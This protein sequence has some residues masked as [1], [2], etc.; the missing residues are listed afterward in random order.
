MLLTEQQIK[1]IILEEAKKYLEEIKRRMTP[2]DYD[3]FMQ[4]YSA[5]LSYKSKYPEPKTSQEQHDQ[6][7]VFFMVYGEA[8]GDVTME[9]PL[10]DWPLCP[11]VRP[12][13]DLL[14][15]QRYLTR[16]HNIPYSNVIDEDGDPTMKNPWSYVKALVAIHSKDIDKI[17]QHQNLQRGE[18]ESSMA[19][20]KNIEKQR[21]LRKL[22][23]TLENIIKEEVIKTLEKT[24]ERK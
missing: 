5:S 3:K 11:D 14:A 24:L 12:C 7:E 22:G 15:V 13:E 8:R 17:K 6:E 23:V 21:A 18:K 2:Q 16:V 1:D 19:L 20:Q 4:R 10:E 9:K